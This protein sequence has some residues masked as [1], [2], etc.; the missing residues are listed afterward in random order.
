MS[1]IAKKIGI[2]KLREGLPN[3]LRVFREGFIDF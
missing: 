1:N 2:I 3:F